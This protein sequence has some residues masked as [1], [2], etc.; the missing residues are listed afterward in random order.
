MKKVLISFIVLWLAGCAVI[1]IIFALSKEPVLDMAT[2]N[3][4]VMDGN[5]VNK[6]LQQE[7][8]QLTQERQT[9]ELK[10]RIAMYVYTGIIA[11][12]GII[13]YLY[14]E[15]RVMKPFR[16]LKRF[17]RDVA[18]GNLDIPLEMDVHGNFGV[19]TESFDLMREELKTARENERSADRS[20]KELVCFA[21]SSRASCSR[22]QQGYGKT[23]EILLCR[24]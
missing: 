14:C 22:T 10:L 7:Q 17:A 6:R 23:G 15:K 18:L 16:K 13:L 8:A 9:R 24:S 5:N 2:V 21:G 4:I 19:F 11:L 1:N 3:D 20:K 12:F